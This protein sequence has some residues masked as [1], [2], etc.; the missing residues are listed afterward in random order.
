MMKQKGKED[1]PRGGRAARASRPARRSKRPQKR[2]TAAG[3]DLRKPKYQAK[4][5]FF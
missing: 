3:Q 1:A 5:Y 2:L 4:A